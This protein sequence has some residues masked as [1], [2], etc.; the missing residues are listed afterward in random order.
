[1]DEQEA[2][3]NLEVL[4]GGGE[5]AFRL[6]RLYSAADTASGRE[7]QTKKEIFTQMALDDGYV[8][9]AIVAYLDYVA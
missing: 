5:R 4:C 6:M 2:T 9:A 8:V 3:D 7:T 1:M